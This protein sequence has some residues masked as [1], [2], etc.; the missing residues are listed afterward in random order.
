MYNWNHFHQR[1]LTLDLHAVL[2]CRRRLFEF[3]NCF[4]SACNVC[5]ERY[6]VHCH[7]ISDTS[8]CQGHEHRL[9]FYDK[10]EGQCNGCGNNLEDVYA[11][12]ECNFAVEFGCLTFPDKIQHKCDEH[13]LMQFVKEEEMQ[14]IAHKNCVIDAYS[15]MKLGKTYT[16]KDHPHPLTFTRKIYDY[17]P[18]CHICEEHCEDLSAECLENGCNYIVHWKC[19]DPYRKYILRR[20]KW[21]P[22]GEDKGVDD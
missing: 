4:S 10:Y 5:E 6:C 20:L 7:Q 8:T 22:K 9:F 12:K 19:I 2:F 11:S 3:N 18:E 17:P 15:Y 1:P 13:P 14:A 21:Q 16:T